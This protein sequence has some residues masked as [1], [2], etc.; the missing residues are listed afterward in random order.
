MKTINLYYVTPLV[1]AIAM[2]NATSAYAQ[3]GI[4]LGGSAGM[5]TSSSMSGSLMGMSASSSLNSGLSASNSL[6]INGGLGAL[7]SVINSINHSASASGNANGMVELS[8]LGDLSAGGDTNGV[9]DLVSALSSNAQAPSLPGLNA[10]SHVSSVTEAAATATAGQP[11]ATPQPSSEPAT[12]EPT[13]PEKPKA[14]NGIVATLQNSTEAVGAISGSGNA[15]ASFVATVESA[16]SSTTD[17]SARYRDTPAPKSPEETSEGTQPDSDPAAPQEN[18]PGNDLFA[19]LVSAS[20]I[21]GSF[22]GAA[23]IP[24]T[25]NASADTVVSS[26]TEMT[27]SGNATEPQSSDAAPD[28]QK[29]DV[30]NDLF[31]AVESST[32]AA[33]SANGGASIQDSVVAALEASGS[34]A[35]EG[36]ISVSNIS[37]GDYLNVAGSSITDASLE[38]A[39]EGSDIASILLASQFQSTQELTSSLE[40]SGQSLTATAASSTEAASNASASTQ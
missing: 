18:D 16:V 6:S 24:S 7:D 23:A 31:A 8:G 21:A 25:A 36:A 12:S 28:D 9:V 2:A 26:V 15:P 17:A 19:S 3:L 33:G 35:S 37:N 39:I 22:T 29:S 30:Q 10:D 32:K 13:E 27:A 5:S 4:N 14:D 38:G 20:A 11:S 34:S 40:T 1:A